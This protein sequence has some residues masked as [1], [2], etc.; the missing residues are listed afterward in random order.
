MDNREYTVTQFKT[1]GSIIVKGS[2]INQVLN[3]LFEDLRVDK[4]NIELCGLIEWRI[5]KLQ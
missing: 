1:F 5:S 2:E 4:F 3:W